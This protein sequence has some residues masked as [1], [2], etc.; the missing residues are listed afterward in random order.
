MSPAFSFYI[1][2][3]LYKAGLADVAEATY[4][5]AWGWCLAQGCRTVP[6]FFITTHSMCHAWSACP[7]YYLSRHMVGIHFD[8]SDWNTV[9]LQAQCGDDIDYAHGIMPHPKGQIEVKWS[10]D[11]NGQRQYNIVNVPAGVDVVYA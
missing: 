2:D 7:T 6:E 4:R 3:G 9:T 1:I 5:E 10:R 11:A 8:A